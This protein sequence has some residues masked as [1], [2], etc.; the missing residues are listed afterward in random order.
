MTNDDLPEQLVDL[1]SAPTTTWSGVEAL[2]NQNIRLLLRADLDN[3]LALRVI[4]RH[5]LSDW[6]WKVGWTTV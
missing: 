3:T 6:S 5:G 1:D 4:R 2:F